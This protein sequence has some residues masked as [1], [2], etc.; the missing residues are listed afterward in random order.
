LLEDV[1]R[2]EQGALPAYTE[3]DFRQADQALNRVYKE[4][5]AKEFSE[6]TITAA[7]IKA[8]EKAWLA[9]RDAWIALAAQRYAQVAPAAFKVWLTKQRT[10]QLN[11]L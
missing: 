5:L 7:G 11:Q 1:R 2:F 3:D 4:T 6:T 8:T 9:Y 10:E